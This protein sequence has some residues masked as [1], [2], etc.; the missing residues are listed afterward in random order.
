MRRTVPQ[1]SSRTARLT[2]ALGL[3]AGLVTGCSGGGA[4]E[5]PPPPPPMPRFATITELGTA[6]GEQMKIEKSAKLTVTGSASG[7]TTPVESSV[8]EGLIRYEATGPSMQ[9]AQKVSQPGQPPTEIVMVVLPDQAYVKPPSTVGLPP[10]KTWV[11]IEPTATDPVSQQFN[12]II[13]SVREN[14]DPT[15]SF[16]QFGDAATIVESAEEPLDGTRTVRYKIRVD[17]AKAASREQNPQIKQA[18][19]ETVRS[20]TPT[21]DSSLWLDE[22]SRPLRVS[23]QQPLPNNQG[24][25]NLEVRYRDWGQP[26]EINAPP[27]DQVIAG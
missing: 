16:T 3:L 17:L 25:Y 12:A 6:T 5:A 26:V 22:K 23:F 1:F 8:G 4:P 18:L 2:V 7:S 13:Q 27:A 21:V 24:T 15:Q 19:E 9:L 20:G 10:G 11:R 14:A